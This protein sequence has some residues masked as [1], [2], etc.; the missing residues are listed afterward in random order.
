MEMEMKIK[1]KMKRGRKDGWE[2]SRLDIKERS[3]ESP[4][5]GRYALSSFH[6]RSPLP[7]ISHLLLPSDTQL[8]T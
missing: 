1:M 7:L 2:G 8:K 3:L 5:T 4:I 6:R